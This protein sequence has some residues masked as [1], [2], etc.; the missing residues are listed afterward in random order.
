MKINRA[1]FVPFYVHT[2]TGAVAWNLPEMGSPP[3]GGASVKT[4]RSAVDAIPLPAYTKAAEAVGV[5]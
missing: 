3:S 4:P 5:L 1:T 2:G